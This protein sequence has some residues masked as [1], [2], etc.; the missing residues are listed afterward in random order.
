MDTVVTNSFERWFAQLSDRLVPFVPRSIT[1]NQVT[2]AG[3]AVSIGGS[4]S[5]Y[6]AGQHSLWLLVAMAAILLHILGDGVDGAL[7]RARLQTSARGCFLDQMLDNIA[8][9]AM[10]LAIAFSG[11]ARLEV[12][13]FAMLLILLHAILIQYWMILRNKRVFPVI[14]PVDYE[15]LVLGSVVFTFAWPGVVVS[16][17]GVELGWFDLFFGI[18]AV[19]S[20]IDLGRSMRR[21]IAEL[22][23]A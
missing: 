6:L 14:G 12:L 11:L 21:L 3:F 13:V 8:F 1:P 19:L 15:L 18:G 9:V 22:E 16:L 5:L 10:P 7:A 20:A 4:L 17:G 23:G 2:A